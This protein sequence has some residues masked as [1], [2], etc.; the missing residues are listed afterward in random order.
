MS[1]IE[2]SSIPHP[3]TPSG[4]FYS[5]AAAKLADVS[6][7]ETGLEQGPRLSAPTCPFCKYKLS[8]TLAASGAKSG[9]VFS[10]SHRSLFEKEDVQETAAP[11]HTACTL[12]SRGRSLEEPAFWADSEPPNTFHITNS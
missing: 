3:V 1:A 5:V 9:L 6:F 10:Y 2:F 4:A 8:I 12:Q 11:P 7:K